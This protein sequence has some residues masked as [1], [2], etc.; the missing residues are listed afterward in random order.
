MVRLHLRKGLEMPNYIF[1]PLLVM[2]FAGPAVAFM[3]SVVFLCRPYNSLAMVIG[4]VLMIGLHVGLVVYGVDTHPTWWADDNVIA[5]G[6]MYSFVGLFGNAVGFVGADRL[7][8]KLDMEGYWADCR[9]RKQ[10][11]LRRVS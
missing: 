6:F 1:L 10:P 2:S 8:K 5:W 3:A 9:E 7:D 4:A 11:K